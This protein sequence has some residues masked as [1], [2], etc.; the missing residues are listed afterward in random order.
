MNININKLKSEHFLGLSLIADDLEGSQFIEDKCVGDIL[1]GLDNFGDGNK[2]KIKDRNGDKKEEN[3][4]EENKTK[5]NY[6]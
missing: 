1:N 3:E 2:N 5:E 4:K 6:I